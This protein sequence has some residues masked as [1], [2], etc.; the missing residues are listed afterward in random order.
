MC[1]AISYIFLYPLRE[2]HV[3]VIING[4]LWIGDHEV[5]LEVVPWID[6]WE[7]QHK[8]YGKL[9]YYRWV[10]LGVVYPILLLAAVDADPGFTIIDTS[11]IDVPVALY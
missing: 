3:Q 4:C 10:C 8:L 6:D 5:H 9:H 1:N 7:Y 11:G 2:I